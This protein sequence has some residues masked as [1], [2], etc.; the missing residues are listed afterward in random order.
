MTPISAAPGH[1]RYLNVD[2]NGGSPSSGTGSPQMNQDPREG[3]ERVLNLNCVLKAKVVV[4]QREEEVR[5]TGAWKLER[6][7]GGG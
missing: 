2:S 1:L 5:W 3:E 4:Q 7:W 6:T